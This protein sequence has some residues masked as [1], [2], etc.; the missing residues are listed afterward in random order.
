MEKGNICDCKKSGVEK[1][2]SLND[3]FVYL[4]A[5]GENNCTYIGMTNNMTRRLR[6]HNGEIVGGARYTTLKRGEGSWYYYGYVMN[7]SKSMALSIEKK[8]QKRTRKTKGSSP[9]DRRLNCIEQFLRDEYS[10]DGIS[11]LRATSTTQ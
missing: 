3:Y 2:A 4:L 5:N 8:I 1:S 10:H 7:L 6:Q 11:F 9:L